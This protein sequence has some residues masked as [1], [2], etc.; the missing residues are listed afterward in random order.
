MFS[1]QETT[2]KI[3]ELQSDILA[4]RLDG[5]PYLR[6]HVLI[7]KN[8]RLMTASQF[9]IGAINEILKSSESNEVTTK[10]GLTEIYNV[11][12]HVGIKPE[13][14]KQVLSKADSLI[15]LVLKIEKRLNTIDAA[16]TLDQQ[17]VFE[18]EGTPQFTFELSHKP[19][20]DIAFY[21]NGIR[22]VNAENDR[23][24]EMDYDN[25]TVRWTFTAA[26]GGFDITN[27][28]VVISYDFLIAEEE[29]EEG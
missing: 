24:Y 11:L 1:G 13:L 21:I 14:A 10:A 27:S 17:D 26:R 4:E 2:N 18:V 29:E 6:S 3:M 12:G 23:V 20:S 15:E 16:A 22:Y 19:S 7:S 28:T 5:N 25:N 9:I 8:K